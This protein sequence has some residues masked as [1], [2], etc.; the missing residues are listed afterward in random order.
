MR[1]QAC[2]GH[3]LGRA[4]T[5]SRAWLHSQVSHRQQIYQ[6]LFKV[7][8]LV[9]AAFAYPVLQDSRSI[10]ISQPYMSRKAER[11]MVSKKTTPMSSSSEY[12][13]AS[14]VCLCISHPRER[15]QTAKS[16]PDLSYRDG[17]S[18]NVAPASAHR[19][20]ISLFV[21]L[22]CKSTWGVSAF[23][24]CQEPLLARWPQA[25]RCPSKPHPP[26]KL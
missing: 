22:C 9:S 24:L 23:L 25:V 6:L 8:P 5:P 20:I 4:S 14:S 10:P 15:R 12:A 16:N 19:S 13:V 1:T 11:M 3:S 2:I 26:H 17:I 21:K 7:F 18:P